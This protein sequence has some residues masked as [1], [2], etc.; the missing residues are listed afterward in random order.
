MLLV[1]YI[2][3]QKSEHLHITRLIMRTLYLF[4]A[5]ACD[6]YMNAGASSDYDSNASNSTD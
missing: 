4:G 1:D 6:G 3:F 5:G 2:H